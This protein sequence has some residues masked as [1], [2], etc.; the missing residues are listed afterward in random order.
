MTQGF[1]FIV[2]S[3]CET[4]LGIVMAHPIEV[5][6]TRCLVIEDPADVARYAQAGRA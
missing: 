4:T 6:C 1:E 2:C 5:I 3:R